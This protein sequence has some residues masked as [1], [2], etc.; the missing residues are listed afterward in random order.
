MIIR[1]IINC[2]SMWNGIE[3]PRALK[4]SEFV[5]LLFFFMPTTQ[6]ASKVVFWGFISI[7][8]IIIPPPWERIE[9]SFKLCHLLRPSVEV[10]DIKS[11]FGFK[12]C[13]F[14]LTHSYLDKL[15]FWYFFE[16]LFEN[17]RAT[18]TNID[19]T[20]VVIIIL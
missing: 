18:D 10:W 3:T 12:Y 14:S 4:M 2:F 5:L 15:I 8:Y 16:R 7:R 17:I 1:I 13:L 6:S 19:N 11:N 9:H 20:I